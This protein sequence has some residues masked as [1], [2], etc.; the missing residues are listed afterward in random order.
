MASHDKLSAD[1]V[2]LAIQLLGIEQE[3]TADTLTEV[4]TFYT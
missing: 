2:C 3:S 1:V 4:P